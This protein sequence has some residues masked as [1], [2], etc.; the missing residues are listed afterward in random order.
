[1]VVVRKDSVIVDQPAG[2]PRQANINGVLFPPFFQVDNIRTAKTLE[3]FPDDV[4]VLTYPKCG[5][6]WV[7]HIACQLLIENYELRPGKEL[8]KYAP[9]IELVGGEVASHIPRPRILKSHLS[10][11]NLPTLNGSKCILVWRNPK[12]TLISWFH[13]IRN[14]KGYNWENGDFNVFFEMF[15]EGRIPWGS[16]FD[17]HKAWLP[18]LKDPNVLLIKFE[19]MVADLPTSVV[20]IGEFLGG[21]AAAVTHNP[22]ALASTL[23]NST[24]EAMKRDQ[25]R[26]FP[27]VLRNPAQFIR[28]GVTRD[29]KNYLSKE[30]SDRIDQMFAKHFRES[31]VEEWWK[32]EMAWEG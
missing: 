12:D 24:F 26:W 27:I 16:Y 17:Y 10:A 19:E 20:R 25:N 13:L 7:Q 28:K 18:Y 8:F 11:Q 32:N 9:M 5:T 14:I 1:M 31:D 15:C 29:W 2:E 30:Q 23:E 3:T 4:F 21:R 22:K 6:T